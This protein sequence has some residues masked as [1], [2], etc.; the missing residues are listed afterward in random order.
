MKSSEVLDFLN[1]LNVPDDTMII[2]IFHN[3]NMAKL[4][5]EFLEKS[6]DNSNVLN[7]F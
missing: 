3:K 5:R 6:K 7:K 2:V 1:T 4:C